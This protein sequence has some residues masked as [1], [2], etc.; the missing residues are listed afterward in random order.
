MCPAGGTRAGLGIP[1]E[2]NRTRGTGADWVLGADWT[3]LD[4]P[5]TARMH[6]A[7]HGIYLPDSG[8]R[9]HGYTVQ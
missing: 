3:G 7:T 9:L 8:H 5:N 1:E 2:R 4:W 6:T